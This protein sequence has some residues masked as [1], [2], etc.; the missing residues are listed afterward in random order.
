MQLQILYWGL[1]MTDDY[2]QSYCEEG[3]GYLVKTIKMIKA[4]KVVI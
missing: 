4:V 1:T 2:K 3:L